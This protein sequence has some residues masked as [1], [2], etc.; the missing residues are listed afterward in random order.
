MI[1]KSFYRDI[2]VENENN[3]DRILCLANK[4]K[5]KEFEVEYVYARFKPKVQKEYEKMAKKK[6][7]D[8]EV[9]HPLFRISDGK[10]NLYFDWLMSGFSIREI[11]IFEEYKFEYL[12][13]YSLK[14]LLNACINS[15]SE[16]F[17]LKEN[18]CMH[19][20]RKVREAL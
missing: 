10:N 5:D 6:G 16:I 9:H 13:Y 18:N 2:I 3:Y 19:W 20:G 14:S 7:Y 1:K 4:L 17:N 11:L 12:G 8:I 15:S